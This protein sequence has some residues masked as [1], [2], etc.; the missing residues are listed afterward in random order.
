[1][2]EPVSCRP[3]FR[4]VAIRSGFGAL[5]IVYFALGVVLLRVAILGTRPHE[6]GVPAAL[7][8][9][10]SQSYGKWLL[11]GVVAGLAAIAAAH[12]AEAAFGHRGPIVRIGLAGNAIGYVVLATTAA[13]LLLHLRE[14]DGALEK[15]GASW[16]FRES[17][18]PAV[19]EVI[20]VAVVIGGLWELGQGVLG[21]LSFRRDLLPR[22][23]AS[24]LAAICRFGLAARGLVLVALG[25]FLVLAAEQL[26]PRRVP[27]MGGA[28]RALSQTALGPILTAVIAFGLCA[29]GVYMWTLMLLKRKV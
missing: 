23:L 20:G 10:L 8:L 29:F 2:R 9:L 21:R 5:G 17:W 7:R 24:V 14:P 15:A 28:L 19:A 3:V 18:G 12:A 16:L 4:R 26:D 27:T 11:G 6:P 25:Y 22:S 1:M 13:R